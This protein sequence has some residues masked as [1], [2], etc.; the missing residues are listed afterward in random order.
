[1]AK[2]LF[3]RANHPQRLPEAPAPS[4]TSASDGMESA[5]ALARRYLPD[6][7]RL[8]AGIAFAPDSEAALHTRIS[9]QG[10]R[11]DCGRDPASDPGPRH[12]MRG[13]VTAA[14]R[15]DCIPRPPRRNHSQRSVGARAAAQEWSEANKA[16]RDA[17]R[18]P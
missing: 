7:V 6:A 17:G 15:I 13:L 9:R 4:S 18:I 16:R 8:F 2:T 5:R 10:D 12:R 3:E 11:G 14:N 1:M